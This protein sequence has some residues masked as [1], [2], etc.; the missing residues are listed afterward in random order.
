M[1]SMCHNN[2]VFKPLISEKMINWKTKIVFINSWDYGNLLCGLVNPFY[3]NYIK[4]I[5]IYCK[6]N[7][8]SVL[9]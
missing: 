9:F 3:E 1:Y 5:G 2:I 8:L 6:K 4:K 7:V